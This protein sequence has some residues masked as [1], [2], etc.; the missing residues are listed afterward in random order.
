MRV[1]HFLA[2]S[3]TA[4]DVRGESAKV[5]RERGLFS[6]DSRL[7]SVAPFGPSGD[8]LRTRT[9]PQYTRRHREKRKRKPFGE[10]PNTKNTH[11][12]RKLRAAQMH[13]H[14]TAARKVM[15]RPG[16]GAPAAWHVSRAPPC[17]SFTCIPLSHSVV[18][19]INSR[20]VPLL[21]EERE[22]SLCTAQNVFPAVRTHRDDVEETDK[23]TGRTLAPRPSCE[24]AHRQGV[25]R[26][27]T[28]KK[29]FSPCMLH[30]PLRKHNEGVDEKT[31]TLWKG[32]G[33]VSLQR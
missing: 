26:N 18:L 10:K 15:R 32:A 24:R 23:V 3:K 19:S 4:G 14:N 28:Q 12:R 11:T 30:H 5:P 29:K 22:R 21:V 20:Q 7:R 2:E 9:A 1:C 25:V 8:E 33:G 13:T 16:R 27:Q 31:E 6:D 17:R